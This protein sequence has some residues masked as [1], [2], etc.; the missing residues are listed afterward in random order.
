[1][2]DETTTD[3]NPAGLPSDRLY[4]PEQDMWVR[5]EEDGLVRLGATH[6]VAAHGQFM[7]FTPRPVQSVI[8]RDRSLGV[9]ET[10]KTAVAVHSPLSG[11]ILEVNAAVVGDPAPIERDPYG[12]GWMFRMAPSNLEAEREFLLDAAAYARW[13]EPRE[14]EKQAAKPIADEFEEDLSVDPNRGY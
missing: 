13:L 6:L 12:A 11:T 3:D 1:M 7:Y 8:E 4:A 14:K 10:A 2:T 5:L 9:M